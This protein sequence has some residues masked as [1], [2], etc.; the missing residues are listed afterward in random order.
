MLRGAVVE[1]VVALFVGGGCRH[2]RG[3]SYE[4]RDAGDA[5]A[6]SEEPEGILQE[7]ADLG[8]G[9]ACLT[10]PQEQCSEAESACLEDADFCEVAGAR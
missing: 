6:A 2:D 4:G 9:D 10:C 7:Y 5:D 8:D 1:G 3:A